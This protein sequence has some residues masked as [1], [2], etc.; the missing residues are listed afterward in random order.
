LARAAETALWLATTRDALTPLADPVNAEP[1]AA[2]MKGV[3]PFLGIK[4]QP[5]REALKRAWSALPPPDERSLA[6][7][8]QTL[9]TWPEREYQYAACDL[10]GRQS[11]S[12]AASFIRSPVEALVTTKSWWDT[13]DSLGSA[14]ITPVVARNPALVEL[15]WAWLDS[16]NT[17]LVRAAIQHQRGLKSATDLDR[18]FAMCDRFHADREFFIA[19][20]I[21]WA[22]RDVTAWD[23]DSVERFVDDHPSLSPVARREA[24]RGLARSV[25]PS[26]APARPSAP[27]G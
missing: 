14:A 13:V 5:R 17:W 2:Y 8:C 24:L 20:A 26:T 19:K 27:P 23:P 25:R 16:G 10:L 7:I 11:R 22:L 9:W 12:L 21:G 3:A 6:D 18:L 15:M 1:M 4:T